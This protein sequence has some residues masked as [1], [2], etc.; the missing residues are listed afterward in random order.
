FD[1]RHG[2]F[3]RAPK[4]PNAGAIDLLLDHALDDAAAWAQRVV[5][6]SLHAMARGG[7]FDQL[8]GGFHRYATDTRWLV[9][10][11]EKMAYDNGVLLEAYARA[12]AVFRDPLYRAA[13]EGI[14][15][16]Y[17]E[18]AP[19]LREAGGF[20]ASQDADVGPHDDGDYWTWAR[21]EIRE[22]LGGDDL[23]ER[24]A[25]LR[26]GLDRSDA[27]MPSDR[28]RHVLYLAQDAAEIAAEVGVDEAEAERLVAEVT[29]RLKEIGRAHV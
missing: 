6:E 9:P 17:R 19:G 10:H 2:G 13:A 8:G 26:F 1:F 18:A 28:T 3:G 23:L 22:A 5:V 20:P 27:T 15:A 14:V 16:Y 24:V 29:S 7:I 11:F 21:E 25:V 4:F 12:Y